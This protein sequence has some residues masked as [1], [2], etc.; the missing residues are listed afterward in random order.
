MLDALR[1]V[2]TAVAKKDYVPALTHYRIKDGRVTGFNGTIGL[3]SSIDVDLDIYPNATKLL[4]AIAACPGTITLNMTA[5]GKLTVRSGKFRTHVD[6]LEDESAYFVEPEGQEVDL[7]PNFMEGIKALQPAM[8]IDASRPWAM[9]IKLQSQSMFV[10]N[11]VLLA[12][13]WHGSTIPIDVVIPSVAIDELIRIKQ[14]PTKVQVTDNSISFWYGEDRWLR[15]SLV[16]STGWPTDRLPELFSHSQG[17]QL[18]FPGDFF[19][20]VDKL[21]PFVN[22]AGTVFVLPDRMATSLV[23]GEGASV[24][25]VMSGVDEPQA[26]NQKQLV[27]LGLLAKTIDWTSYPR[28][29]MFQ[30]N[31][32]RGVLIGQRV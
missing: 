25:L 15:T 7:G 18:P 29:C 10:T 16:E 32:L 14:P 3:S 27:L 5:G 19:E 9:G 1:F 2:A 4:A 11:N 17:P 13:Y 20:T 6:C 22:D 28:P 8:G 23:D 26:Y 31:R 21:K 12:E 24:E 30:G